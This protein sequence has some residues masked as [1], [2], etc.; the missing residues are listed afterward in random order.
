[1]QSGTDADFEENISPEAEENKP[2]KPANL[3]TEDGES[4]EDPGLW[5]GQK[6]RTPRGNGIVVQRWPS[7]IG[8]KLNATQEVIYFRG[9]GELAQVH[10]VLT[11]GPTTEG[12]ANHT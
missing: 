3:Q 9:E 1:L 2:A 11:Q 4:G 12:G 8:V 6:V 7:L 5:I 10:L